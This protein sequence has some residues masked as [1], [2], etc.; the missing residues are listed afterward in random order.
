MLACLIYYD[1]KFKNTY[2]LGSWYRFSSECFVGVQRSFC[3]LNL[4]PIP[5]VNVDSS[6]AT[7]FKKLKKECCLPWVKTHYLFGVSFR[8]QVLFILEQSHCS[9]SMGT[10][11]WKS[12]NV[13]QTHGLLRPEE[14]LISSAESFAPLFIQHLTAW[15]S[16]PARKLLFL[17]SAIKRMNCWMAFFTKLGVSY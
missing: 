8:E 1:L 15:V 5:F 2:F 13:R 3:L 14:L 10:H 12:Y 4:L 11:L 17:R 9:H 16:N 7:L 6:L